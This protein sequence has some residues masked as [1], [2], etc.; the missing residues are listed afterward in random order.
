MGLCGS[1]LFYPRYTDEVYPLIRKWLP[2]Y[3]QTYAE[4][5][6]KY[7]SPLDLFLGGFIQYMKTV[8]HYTI[9]EKLDEKVLW[10]MVGN[11]VETVYPNMILF[12]G[13]M[14]RR[15]Y[16]T[17]VSGLRMKQLP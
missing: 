4:L 10:F 16:P 9:P 2:E 8:K 13:R 3:I 15:G 14:R 11:A 17:Y 5:N 12:K 6:E 1:V 7:Y